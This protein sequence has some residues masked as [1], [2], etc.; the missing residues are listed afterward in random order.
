MKKKK[1]SA[2]LTTVLLSTALLTPSFSATDINYAESLKTL[3]LLKGSDK[4]FELERTP[5]RAEISAML[6]NL[7]GATEELPKENY[8]HP[9]NDVPKWADAIV[10]YMYEKGI[11]SGISADTFGANQPAT[12]LDYM[13][14]VL[15]ALGYDN[16]D[17]DYRASV[18]FATEIGL[19]DEATA[20]ALKT[21]TF[22]R[23]DMIL[24]SSMALE[25]PLKNTP[26]MTLKS[27]LIGIGAIA[28]DTPP[29]SLS[30]YS[31]TYT[32]DLGDVTMPHILEDT[33][34]DITIEQKLL[35]HLI[36]CQ[37]KTGAFTEW[38][39]EPL[40]VDITT[41]ENGQQLAH[42]HNIIDKYQ[43]QSAMQSKFGFSSK[44]D[45][46]M[47]LTIEA[48]HIDRYYEENA[49]SI[50]KDTPITTLDVD[51]VQ[52]LEEKLKTVPFFFLDNHV[53]VA[54][55]YVSENREMGTKLIQASYLLESLQ[56]K[57]A[58][59]E[60]RTFPALE[61][62]AHDTSYISSGSNENI[63]KIIKPSA[64]SNPMFVLLDENRHP[65]EFLILID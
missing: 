62:Y 22:Q 6:I 16:S 28:S 8:L 36:N 12:A 48:M 58:L 26:D 57:I 31:A 25:P 61:F 20:T 14:F 10:G 52:S 44:A 59:F 64:Y 33:L 23:K 18:D 65:V 55:I 13:T 37:Y 45:K 34:F 9:F 4:G 2:A 46:T 56:N 43:P 60:T 24:I 49:S 11:T 41:F 29:S 42:R 51:D 21:N 7:A 54:N 53:S 15:K 35:F 39:G 40:V 1:I 50:A 63:A 30:G 19:V 27:H 17:F 3:G 38:A 32:V 47:T 5:N